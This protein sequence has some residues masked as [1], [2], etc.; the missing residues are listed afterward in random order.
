[1][2][3]L[4]LA[5]LLSL[6]APARPAAAAIQTRHVVIVAIDGARWSE[7]FGNP[8]LGLHPHLIGELS[9]LGSRPA[10]FQNV[11]QTLTVPGMSAI[12]TGTLQPIAND[13]SE[14]PHLPTVFEYLRQQQG[15]PDSLVRIVARKPKLDVLAYSDAPGY[16][17]AYGAHARVGLA[18][19]RQTSDTARAELLR[20]RPTLMLV[21]FG[22]PDIIAHQGDWPGYLEALRV[23]D[24][25]TWALWNDIQADPEMAG[26]TTLFVTNDHGR[27]LDNFGGFQNHGDGCDGC[28]HI[29]MVMDGP[30][31]FAGYQSEAHHDQRA[32]AR[33]AG[34]LLG[35]DMPLADGAVMDDLLLEPSQP[36]GVPPAVDRGAR[37]AL[38]VFPNPSR[39]GAVVRLSGAEAAGARV[40]VLDPRGARIATLRR[41]DVGDGSRWTWDGRDARGRPAPPGHYLVRARTRGG[42][43]RLARLVRLR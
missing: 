13:G 14:R 35:L 21:H 1:M 42:E 6:V 19:D 25:L 10:L 27:H 30:D 22:D 38:E 16:G 15:T 9:A 12:V 24:S 23:A 7:T 2:A 40:E 20:Y 31:C 3:L 11:G 26:R 29:M 28:R 33:T 36:L 41:D 43:V 5:A 4:P 39:A 18:S 17:A 32:I 8:S 34:Y 37:L